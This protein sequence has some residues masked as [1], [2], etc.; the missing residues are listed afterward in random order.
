[1]AGAAAQLVEQ[2]A[3]QQ[4]LTGTPEITFFRVVYKQHTLFALEAVEQAFQGTPEFGRQATAVISKN[5]DLLTRMWLQVRLPD[6]T[7]YAPA[8]SAP[9]ASL[10]VVA[11][12]HV[13]AADAASVTVLGPTSSPA[14]WSRLAVL[15]PPSA[16]AAPSAFA[17]VQVVS[18]ACK[19]PSSDGG[20]DVVVRSYGSGG[21]S[22]FVSLRLTSLAGGS[23]LDSGEPLNMASDS[24]QTHSVATVPDPATGSASYRMEALVR[25]AADGPVLETV[26]LGVLAVAAASPPTGGGGSTTVVPVTLQPGRDRP[27]TVRAWA[28][29]GGTTAAAASA[30]LL[31]LKWCNSV[32]HALLESVELQVGGM[33]FDRHPSQWFDIFSELN[34][35]QEKVEGFNGMVGK[36][37]GYD[38]WDWSRSTGAERTYFVP[39][40]FFFN[41]TPSLALPVTALQQQDVSLNFS[42]R[43]WTQLVRASTPVGALY[44]QPAMLECKLFVDFVFLDSAER[45]M[46]R[47]LPSEYLVEQVQ[48]QTENLEGLEFSDRVA[49]VRAPAAA[50]IAQNRKVR[51]NITQPVK[52]LVWVY[53]PYTALE[54]D[55]QTGNDW[56]AYH[57]PDMPEEEV[58][59]EVRLQLDGNDR[60]APRPGQYFRMVQPYQHLAR[61]PAKRVHAYSFA[62]NASEALPSGTFNMSRVGTVHLYARLSPSMLRGV[63]QVHAVSYNVFRIAGG[64]GGM[65]FPM[66]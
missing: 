17:T 50:V 5:G 19:P 4:Y 64:Q 11:K 29:D 23:A 38:I 62:L 26:D 27:V 52:L 42:F 22:A 40:I 12:A 15:L 20:V 33:R 21:N 66:N 32:G 49:A 60:F 14:S 36:Y 1:M 8:P 56:F 24:D 3:A 59:Q 35:A 51:L 48:T 55:A 16:A 31:N 53:Q 34:E 41:R 54:T 61:V 63:L 45:A 18:V 6:L 28:C 44:P 39:L 7:Q 25:A 46:F 65:A 58:F 2:G 43:P 30:P 13:L 10:P 9:S 37:D 57:M 47:E